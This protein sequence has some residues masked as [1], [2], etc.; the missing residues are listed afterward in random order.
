MTLTSRLANGLCAALVVALVAGCGGAPWHSQ[1]LTRITPPDPPPVPDRKPAAPAAFV[2]QFA[3][4]A[5]VVSAP[6]APS[7]TAVPVTAVTLAASPLTAPSPTVSPSS[8]VSPL[9][10]VSPPPAG[11]LAALP[12]AAPAAATVHIVQPGETLHGVARR[13]AVPIRVVIDANRL[14]PPYVLQV[15]Q[16]LEIPRPRVHVVAAGDTVHGIARRYG[17]DRSELMRLNRIE[18]PYR[19]LLGQKLV[20]PGPAAA[21][22]QRETPAAAQAGALPVPRSAPRIAEPSAAERGA[23]VAG[24][25]PPPPSAPPSAA[26]STSRPAATQSAAIP[27]P[28]VRRGGK[29]LWPLQGQILSSYGPKPGGLHNDGIN[30]AAPRGT[31]IR[32]AENGVVAY[33]G[34]ELRGF[35]NLLLLKHSDGWVTAY[36]HA[37]EILVRRGQRVERGQVIARVGSTGNVSRP[38][39]HFEVR[40]GV[41][42]VDPSRLLEPQISNAGG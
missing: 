22:A 17:V 31:P 30:I 8:A 25:A 9:P 13:Y 40:K 34:N 35:G 16:R 11:Q 41:R 23:R 28:P 2:A 14:T 19:I 42:A 27:T 6:A 10:A 1:N 21:Y 15:R 3:A 20:I 33:S 5:P 39:L 26:R 37:D 18:P 36:A 7:A 12:A 38:Q 29:F 4:A 24:I 32:A